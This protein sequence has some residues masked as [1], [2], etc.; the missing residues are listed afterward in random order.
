MISLKKGQF[1]VLPPV[2]GGRQYQHRSNA[3]EG[4]SNMYFRN[5]QKS[6]NVWAIFR[7]TSISSS[8][9]FKATSLL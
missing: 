8:A 1:G 9:P 5:L 7:V 3:M 2:D 6:V 4:V